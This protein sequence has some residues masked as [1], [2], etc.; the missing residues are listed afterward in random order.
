MTAVWQSS[1]ES[2]PAACTDM[3]TDFVNKKNCAKKYFCFSLNILIQS[4]T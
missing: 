4:I 1:A 2:Q 3:C